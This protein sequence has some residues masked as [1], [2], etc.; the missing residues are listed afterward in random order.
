MPQVW[1]GI[2]YSYHR[3]TGFGG[4]DGSRCLLGGRRSD[5]RPRGASFARRQRKAVG[6]PG[7]PSKERQIEFSVPTDIIFTGRPACRAGRANVPSAAR[8]FAF[9][10]STNR[11]P[12]RSPR[13]RKCP[14][15]WNSLPRSEITLENPTP[16]WLSPTRVQAAEALDFLQVLEG[17]GPGRRNGPAPPGDRGER[18]S[19][20]LR[21]LTA[22]VSAV[23]SAG[24]AFHRTLGRSGRG[25][26]G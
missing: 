8:D 25:Q 6:C 13:S 10:S 18:F 19:I 9:R 3:R 21:A 16:R 15:S 22:G 5:R 12:N 20:C 26:P 24:R 1:R 11:K 14:P 7:F 17:G 23:A 2:S 4:I